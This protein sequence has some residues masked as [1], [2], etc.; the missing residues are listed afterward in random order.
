MGRAVSIVLVDRATVLSGEASTEAVWTGQRVLELAE[1]PALLRDIAS[2]RL[3]ASRSPLGRALTLADGDGAPFKRTCALVRDPQSSFASREHDRFRRYVLEWSSE[4]GLGSFFDQPGE[5][6]RW[7]ERAETAFEALGH[8]TVETVARRL[9]AIEHSSQMY[10]DRQS[11]LRLEAPLPLVF[12]SIRQSADRKTIEVELIRGTNIRGADVRISMEPIPG[13]ML[14]P[15]TLVPPESAPAV[16]PTPPASEVT[17]QLAYGGQRIQRQTY[18]VLPP[19][20]ANL[21]HAALTAFERKTFLT[22]GLFQED[23]AVNARDEDAFERSVSH[24]L[25]LLGFAVFWWG[26]HGGGPLK[27]VM[28]QDQADLLAWSADESTVLVVDCTLMPSQDLKSAKLV[29]RKMQLEAV[30]KARATGRPP[31]VV[32]VL[33]VGVP[34]DQVPSV[35]HGPP[36]EEVTIF[37]LDHMKVALDGLRN[38]APADEIVGALPSTL[39]AGLSAQ[40]RY[41]L[42]PNVF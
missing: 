26:P 21:R 38:G 19:L 1:L 5:P 37:A 41:D 11:L 29:H 30:L 20:S 22:D 24:L 6:Y 35:L 18:R 7:Q 42:M 28:P 4:K 36:S 13:A 9:G 3:A 39:R 23:R 32:P 34:S 16:V 33:A 25:G 40:N 31:R 8:G 14:A 17:L 12:S 10:W 15:L 2:G 27:N